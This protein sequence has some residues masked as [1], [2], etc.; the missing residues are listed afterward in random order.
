MG[1][2]SHCTLCNPYFAEE[3]GRFAIVC[4]NQTRHS[5]T[6]GLKPGI[7]SKMNLGLQPLVVNVL[8]YGF[9]SAEERMVG[10]GSS[11]VAG[12]MGFGGKFDEGRHGIR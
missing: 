11:G 7:G 8:V 12:L 6:V 5:Q 1:R 2:R 10:F 9:I 4:L 3:L